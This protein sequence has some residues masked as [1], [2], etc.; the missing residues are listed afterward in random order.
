MIYPKFKNTGG[1]TLAVVCINILCKKLC[2]YEQTSNWDIRPL[3]Q[4]QRHYAALDAY[5][6]PV[7]I[8]KIEEKTDQ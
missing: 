8:R 7:I 5:I 6:L 3:R 1:S 2:K 4:T